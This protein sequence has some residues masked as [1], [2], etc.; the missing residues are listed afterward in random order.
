MLVDAWTIQ[1]SIHIWWKL[2]RW[3]GRNGRTSFPFRWDQIW[4]LDSHRRSSQYEDHTRTIVVFNK[5]LMLN[6]LI[7]PSTRLFIDLWCCVGSC[8]STQP[9]IIVYHLSSISRDQ[10][11]IEF[12]QCNCVCVWMFTNKMVKQMIEKNVVTEDER[13]EDLSSM[14]T[15]T[16]DRLTLKERH[17]HW[18]MGDSYS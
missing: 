17:H 9:T 11:M 2:P 6:H 14:Y 15:Q 3:L 10:S 18:W 5:I 12:N 7:I 16:S 1:R 8:Y 4:E 13:V